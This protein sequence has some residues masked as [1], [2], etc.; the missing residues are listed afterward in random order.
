MYDTLRLIWPYEEFPKL[1][2][3]QIITFVTDSANTMKA[4]GNDLK[5]LFPDMLTIT[6]VVHAVHI[7]AD[8]IRTLHP[9]LDKF[10][11]LLKQ[12]MARSGARNND[13]RA[14]IAEKYARAKIPS[15][16]VIT[17]WGTWVTFV[18]FLHFHFCDFC[19]FIQSLDPRRDGTAQSA[20]ES[21]I[22]TLQKM[23]GDPESKALLQR[24]IDFIWRNYQLI[25]HFI[26]RLS[27]RR[28]PLKDAYSIVTE[29][30]QYVYAAMENA[31]DEFPDMAE[32]RNAI[33]VQAKWAYVLG[34][35]KDLDKAVERVD[36]EDGDDGLANSPIV[37]VSN[38]KFFHDLRL[39]CRPNQ[40]FKM[41]TLC[42]LVVCKTAIFKEDDAKVGIDLHFAS[43]CKSF[44]KSSGYEF[45]HTT[46]LSNSFAWYPTNIF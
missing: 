4:A 6:C 25:P 16:P 26:K 36:S 46:M 18:C 20:K 2:E 39:F 23:V 22:T 10:I 7:V 41:E 29:F 33:A 35:N 30:S 43:L 19:E 38:E 13:F 31:A 3:K 21:R 34:K 44:Y 37:T 15:F 42:K 17:R 40:H 1:P 5:Y 45:F 24:S 27:Q 9:K 28:M 32:A 8:K 12:I 14:Y 11:G